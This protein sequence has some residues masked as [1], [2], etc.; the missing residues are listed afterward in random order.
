MFHDGGLH[1]IARVSNVTSYMKSCK[2]SQDRKNVFVHGIFFLHA[3]VTSFNLSFLQMSI[4]S[5][6]HT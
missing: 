4:P 2:F 6:V 1:S 3:V 5:L